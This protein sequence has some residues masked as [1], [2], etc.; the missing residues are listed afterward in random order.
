MLAAQNFDAY[1]R[2]AENGHLDILHYLEEKSSAETLQD[3]IAEGNFYSFRYAAANKHF[4]VTNHLLSHASV[5]SYAEAHQY[6]YQQPHV[7][8]F[9]ENKLTEL[10]ARQQQMQARYQDA[11]FDVTSTEEAKLL[12]YIVRNLIRRNNAGLT[13]DLRYLL[14]I[15]SVKALAHT[16]ELVN[17]CCRG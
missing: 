9:I 17:C 7:T 1:R 14:E 4:D 8:P 2:A 10:R 5:F 16:T 15:P 12:F 13:E 6:E 3:M 11:V